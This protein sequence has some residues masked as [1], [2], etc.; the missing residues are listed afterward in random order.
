MSRRRGGYVYGSQWNRTWGQGYNDPYHDDRGA[1]DEYWV[2]WCGICNSNT[3][4]DMSGCAD[5]HNREIEKRR[6]Q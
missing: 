4:H 5:C 1:N 2:K 6:R 3:D